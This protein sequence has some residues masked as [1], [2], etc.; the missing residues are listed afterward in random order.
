MVDIGNP[1]V[2]VLISQSLGAP[3]SEPKS[4][5]SPEFFTGNRLPLVFEGKVIIAD[6]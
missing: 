1:G 3:V 2:I 6:E 5:V 4:V